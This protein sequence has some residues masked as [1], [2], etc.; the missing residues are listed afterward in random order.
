M[1]YWCI[2]AWKYSQSVFQSS[3]V[4]I[5]YLVLEDTFKGNACCL[6]DIVDYK[7][8]VA[9]EE[10]FH[11]GRFHSVVHGGLLLLVCAVFVTSQFD[12]IFIFPNNLLA[13]C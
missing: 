11:V 10:N 7:E 12:V 9:Y 13:V 5:T 1:Y 6:T 8:S 4:L 3:L 2:C